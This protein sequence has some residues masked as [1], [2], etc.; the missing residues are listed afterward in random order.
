MP[1]LLSIILPTKNG[2]PVL[3]ECLGALERQKGVGEFE[4]IAIDSS[5]TDGTRAALVSAC[6]TVIDHPTQIPFDHG[7]SRDLAAVCAPPSKYLVFLTQDAVP[8]T[9]DFLAKLVSA[10][11]SDQSAAGAYARHVSRPEHGIAAEKLLAR[12]EL[13]SSLAPRKVSRE[14]VDEDFPRGFHNREYRFFSNNAS[15]V[16]RDVY[17]RIRFG[18][19]E[20]GEDQRFAARA[21]LLGYSILYQPEAV[22]MHSHEFSFA[23]A[24][25]RQREHSLAMHRLFGD[26]SFIELLALPF[27]ALL[28]LLVEIP[29][30]TNPRILASRIA[31]FAGHARALMDM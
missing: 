27:A 3:A 20:F 6:A 25:E 23:D 12:N 1:A 5:S 24:V 30:L 8:H 10:M 26:H 11:E 14:D 22:V 28:K 29:S 13:V 7:F 31:T 16:R 18:P 19:C 9:D 15:I 17:E 21:I 2:M 4:I